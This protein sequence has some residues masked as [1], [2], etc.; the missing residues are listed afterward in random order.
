MPTGGRPPAFR[1]AG[2]RRKLLFAMALALC[3][4]SPVRA[5]TGIVRLEPRPG[6]QL[7]LFLVRQN[8]APAT[9]VLLSGGK[10]GFGRIENGKPASDNFL[11]RSHELFAAA[12]FNVVVVG[13]SSDSTDWDDELR[14]R[15]DHL[16][17]LAA[18]VDR[19]RGEFGVPVWLVGTSRGTISA[20]AAAIAFGNDKL[21]GV[22]LTASV[23]S[24]RKKGAV[25]K[26][27][28]DRIGIPVLV[29]HHAR[30]ACVYCAPHETEYIIKGLVNAPVKK[31]LLIDGGGEAR[32]DACEALHWHGFVGIEAEAVQAIAAWIGAPR[33]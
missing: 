24:F 22:V 18:V 12:G 4:A 10:G 33:P 13:R 29:V 14:L 31:L 21:A 19:A 23:T 32:G 3:S 25:P 15:P 16:W 1:G 9:V 8:D 30:D 11:V 6:V 5:A 28:L 20:T 2:L 26:Q 7:S 17:D 27:A